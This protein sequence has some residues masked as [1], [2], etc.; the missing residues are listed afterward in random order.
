MAF[1]SVEPAQ[2]FRESE[3]NPNPHARYKQYQC[4]DCGET[5]LHVADNE[6]YTTLIRCPKCMTEDII[7]TG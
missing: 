6:Q 7:A 2:P 5:N 3:W 1:I 4:A